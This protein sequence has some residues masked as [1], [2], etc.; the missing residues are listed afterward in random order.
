MRPK[1]V[2]QR[3]EHLGDAQV[4]DIVDGGDEI[5]PEV[6]KH[7]LPGELSGGD[8]VELLLEVGGEVVFDV[9]AEEVL[10]ERGDEAP[11]VLG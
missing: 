3:I 1:H 10:E 8:Q 9:A 7:V 11:L 5:A 2:V 6:A 4:A